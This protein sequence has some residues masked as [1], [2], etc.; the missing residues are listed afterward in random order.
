M[1]VDVVH[2]RELVGFSV[3]HMFCEQVLRFINTHNKNSEWVP[4]L[5]AFRMYPA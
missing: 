2:N 4:I 5:E 3:Y 1:N